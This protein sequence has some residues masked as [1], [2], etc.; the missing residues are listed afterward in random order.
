MARRAAFAVAVPIVALGACAGPRAP[1]AAP[2]E[3]APV[4][5][6]APAARAPDAGAVD[7][8][9]AAEPLPPMPDSCDGA[10][11]ART[12][13]R[14][15][16]AGGPDAAR[17]RE[18][19]RAVCAKRG[20]IE[21]CATTLDLFGASL[22]PEEAKKAA[23]EACNA[24]VVFEGGAPLQGAACARTGDAEAADGKRFL[25]ISAY[26]KGCRLES[27]DACEAV[28]RLHTELAAEGRDVA[29]VQFPIGG[30]RDSSGAFRL[31]DVGCHLEASA[32]FMAFFSGL[33]A[34]FFDKKKELVACT[35]KDATVPVHWRSHD[36]KM[37]EVHAGGPRGACV[38]RVLEG[39]KTPLA[40]ECG[41]L[42][43]IGAPA[44]AREPS[45]AA[46]PKR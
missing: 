34:P 14:I 45:S 46:P 42:L 8:R 12:C 30:I 9:A 7:A 40:V 26:E 31:D 19:L 36:G 1:T 17:A 38:Q 2:S 28:K 6:V 15:A 44:R 41:A 35:G 25:A 18:S 11:A 13:W 37:H 43:M 22:P 33:G 21:S 20:T 39:T 5:A 16:K 23:H 3:P 29:I 32:D 10:S 4:A 24:Y 27:A